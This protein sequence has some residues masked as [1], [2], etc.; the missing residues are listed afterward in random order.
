MDFCVVFCDNASSSVIY[1]LY[2]RRYLYPP[3]AHILIF[4]GFPEYLITF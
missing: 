1:N 3:V 2:A 4:S